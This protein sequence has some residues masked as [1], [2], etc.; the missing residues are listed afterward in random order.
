MPR[1]SDFIAAAAARLEVAL[2]PATDTDHERELAAAFLGSFDETA[3]NAGFNAAVEAI[4]G[5]DG[6]SNVHFDHPHFIRDRS[7]AYRK[8]REGSGV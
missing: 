1:A 6:M 4:L 8:A 7:A 5:K 2:S 3:F